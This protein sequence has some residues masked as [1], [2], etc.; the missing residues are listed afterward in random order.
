PPRMWGRQRNKSSRLPETRNTPTHVGKTRSAGISSRVISKHPH[1]CGEDEREYRLQS[2]PLETPPRM[3]GRLP[4]LRRSQPE[5]RNTPTHVGKTL[6]CTCLTQAFEK[7]PHA[8]GEDPSAPR[9]NRHH[10]ETPPR[11][12]GRLATN[13]SLGVPP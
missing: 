13:V 12:W 8:C 5:V 1:A 3:W 6:F 10:R 9:R 11:M 4:D 2:S 7:H